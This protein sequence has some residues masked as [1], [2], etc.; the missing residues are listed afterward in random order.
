MKQFTTVLS[1]AFAFCASPAHS[2]YIVRLSWTASSDAAANPSLTY[3]VYRA[4]AC[5]EQ[6]AKINSAPV[7]GTSYVDTNI[8][9]GAAYCY[10]VTAVL[11]SVESVPSNQAVAAVPPGGD[12]QEACE[13]H[14]AIIGWI[15]CVAA[16]PKRTN[17]QTPPR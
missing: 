5:P 6:F 11:S 1:L 10:Q 12:R 4:A 3:N 16:R 7:T 8:G 9:A 15:R 17:P 2:Q 14:G 13:H